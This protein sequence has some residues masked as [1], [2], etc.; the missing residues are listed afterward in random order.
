LPPEAFV[1]VT[2]AD[3]T[4][5][6]P[7]RGKRLVVLDPRSARGL[8]LSVRRA[9][10]GRHVCASL[11]GDPGHGRVRC[12]VYAVRPTEPEVIRHYEGSVYGDNEAAPLSCTAGAII[13]TGFAVA[14]LLADVVKKFATGVT[15]N[16]W[17]SHSWH[18]PIEDRQA[19]TVRFLQLC[20]RFLTVLGQHQLI[21]WCKDL[22]QKLAKESV[23]LSDQEFH[24]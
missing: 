5:L 1:A 10:D 22:L 14:S 15:T 12:P 16:L 11:R 7:R 13:Y 21:V 3:L 23:V 4:R 6:G 20:P 24:S 17:P 2:P 9:A 18:Q 19:G 8:G